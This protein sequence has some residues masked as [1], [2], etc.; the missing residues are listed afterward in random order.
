MS[1][2]P[3]SEP[4]AIVGIGC[5]LP[6]GAD[7]PA[8]LWRMLLERFDAISE[9]PPDRFDIDRLYD[10]RP[11]TPGRVM[12]RYGGFLD[13]IDGLDADFFHIAPREAERLDPQQRL[14]LETTWEAMED[15]GIPATDIAGSNTGVFVGLW[16]NDFEARLFSDLDALDFHMTTGTGRYAASGRLSYFLDLLGPSL[17]I[18]TA[19]SSSLVAVHLARRSLSTGECDLAFAAGANVILQP[20]ITIAYSQS[21]MMAP[22]GRCKFGDASGDGYVRSEGAAVVALKRLSDAV[23]HG[24]RIHAVIRGSAVTNDGRTSGYLATPGQAGQEIMLR[25]AYADAGV[26]PASVQYIEAH[27]TGTAAGDP[28]ELGAIGAVVGAAR[29]ADRPCMVG[30]IKTNCGHT[31]GAAGVA[32]LVK[33][34][35]ALE[36]GRV[37]PSL[38]CTEPNPNVRWDDLHIRVCSEP[39]ALEQGD[40]PAIAGVSSFGIAGTNAHVVLEGPPT[41]GRHGRRGSEGTSVLAISARSRAALQALAREYSELLT[42]GDVTLDDVCAAA[43]TQRTHLEHRMTVI[44]GTVADAVEALDACAHDRSHPALTEGVVDGAAPRVAFV[45]S[46]QGS[47]WLGMAR[48]LAAG[49]PV[50]AH[51]LERCDRA[52]AA[53]AGWSVL[54]V[55]GDPSGTRLDDIDVVQPVLFAV[56]VALAEQWAAWGVAPSVVVGHSM[57]EVA[58]AHVAGALSLED[59]VRVICLRSRQLRRISGRGAM[60]VVDLSRDEAL[61]A[62]AGREDALSIAA[63]NSPRS[64][65]IAG[66]PAAMDDVL[67]KL[68]AVDVFCRLVKVDVASHSPQVEPLL[69]D[70]HDGLAGLSPADSTIPFHSTV[71]AGRLPGTSLGAEYWCDNLRRPVLFSDAIAQI[72]A[73]G[74]V[75]FV[76]ISPHPILLP[77]IEQTPPGAGG[78][79]TTVGTLRRDEPEVAS[80]LGGL[81]TLHTL[82]VPVAWRQ[83]ALPTR[84]VDLPRYPWQRERYWYEARRRT[85]APGADPLLGQRFGD[86]TEPGAIHWQTD[87]D[88]PGFDFVVG[89]RVHDRP[90][91]PA[92][93]FAEMIR[94]AAVEAAGVTSV[95]VRDLSLL[96]TLPVGP[97]SLGTIQTTLRPRM[98]GGFECRVFSGRSDEWRLHA[99]ATVGRAPDAGSSE[100]LAID[101]VRSRCPDHRDA[102]DHQAR[103]RAHGLAYSGRFESVAECWVGTGEVLGRLRVPGAGGRDPSDGRIPIVDASLQLAIAAVSEV[104]DGQ[105]LLPVTVAS[106]VIEGDPIDGDVW[107]HVRL[108]ANDGRTIRCDVGLFDPS[109]TS[110]GALRNVELVR[111]GSTSAHLDDLVY[112]LEWRAADDASVDLHVDPDAVGGWIV[113]ANDEVAAEL[114]RWLRAAGDGCVVVAPGDRLDLADEDV[115]IEAGS[116][117]DHRA[118]L[119]HALDRFDGQCRGIVYAWGTALAHLDSDTVADADVLGVAAPVALVRATSAVFDARGDASPPLWILTS[120]AQRVG[121]D[122]DTVA[123]PQALLW[124]LG[125]VVRSE[126]PGLRCRLLDA[127]PGASDPADIVAELR[128]IGSRGEVA[129][130]AGRR[131][132]PTL[133]RARLDARSR[134]R[135]ADADS[136]RLVAA[137]PGS[138]DDLR[139][140][141][142]PRRAPGPDEVE[143]EIASAALN[144]LDVLKAMGV[145]P[146]LEPGPDVAL[147]AEGAGTVVAVGAD[148]TSHR[149]GDEVV[150]LTD[151]YATT[152]TLASH[153]T[154]PA[155]FAIAKPEHLSHGAASALPVAYVTAYYGLVELARL[156]AGERVLVHSATGGVGLAAIEIARH[157]GAEVYATAGT[158]AKREQLRAMGITHVYDSRSTAFARGVLA[159]TDGAGVDVVLNSLTG[160]AIPAGLGALANRGRFVELGK[161]DVYGG[162]R[163][164]MDHLKRNVSF[165]VVDLAGLTDDR[166]ELVAE[167]FGSVMALIEDGRLAPLPITVVAVTEAAD[168]FR[169][170]AQAGHVGKLVI[171]LPAE[172]VTVDVGVVRPDATYLITGGTGALGLAV[173]QRFVRLGARHLA[174]VGRSAPSTPAAEVIEDLRRSGASV[175]VLRADVADASGLTGVLAG[176]RASFP[177]I[178]GVVHAA[179]VLADATL[180]QLDVERQ[181]AALAPKL[182][183]GWNVHA[184]TAHDPLDFFVAFSSVAG[185]LGLA[186][187]ANYAA[188]NAFLDALCEARR[189]DDRPALSVDWGPWAEIGLAA[190]SDQRGGR[191]QER[192]L[193]GLRTSEALDVLERLIGSDRSHGVVM[194]FDPDRWARGSSEGSSMLVSLIGDADESGGAPV[195]LRERLHAAPAGVRRR[196]VMEEA[197][198]E[199]LAPVVRSTP[200]RI[201]RTRPLEAMGVD[202]LMALEFRNRLETESG[203][204]LSATLVF[205]YPTVAAI[206]EYVAV[207]MGVALD[208]TAADADTAPVAIDESN[209]IEDSMATRADVEALLAQELEAVERVLGADGRSSR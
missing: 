3:A 144:F 21:R 43:A 70:L 191:L 149:V 126:R 107:A 177:P 56:Q 208:R 96:E 98:E 113:Y 163:L 166:P 175:D 89:H 167:L 64:T 47:Q 109:G 5:R 19:C 31:E 189:L 176:L 39:H 36:H 186:G 165:F 194:R 110:V 106:A 202:S 45:F 137:Q 69:A 155:R 152:S 112:E 33:V 71:V 60:A 13:H 85:A 183:G 184:A 81:A 121:P 46:G 18:D 84:H 32:G 200:E 48:E 118:A 105:P 125:R 157:I 188:G 25:R 123:A 119:T 66:D 179:G 22:D 187:Q 58:A 28:V 122:D 115:T 29:P 37:P 104:A 173:A 65:V 148:V 20:T 207:R 91:L 101:D 12:S 62:I 93:G 23:D 182:A 156:R 190:A 168:A 97:D 75:V 4:I 146:G 10:P 135:D 138:L 160:E 158:E 9:V 7:T 141:I 209:Q 206:A 40:A 82:G 76:E 17:T 196:A 139:L 127:D 16:I 74:H 170:M 199:Q 130:R 8:T 195:G 2:A 192:G 162:A 180:D 24:D 14:L 72:V 51:A 145:Y 181:R 143:V 38:H 103:M 27:G 102:S 68:R 67:G 120:G 161:R 87:A 117:D 142:A 34:A 61:A 124:G 86:A 26:D 44:A 116:V 185:V 80:M 6:G 59:A 174:L 90:I 49:E 133:Q 201:D 100:R 94:A 164:P 136:F 35:L 55:L 52:I 147:G 57:G 205:N 154:V 169:T 79:A 128:S 54:D 198:C 77:A 42:A 108:L 92:A 153:V 50:F 172:P 53:A 140:R 63:S 131:L 197:V 88:A 1:A 151:S 114:A 73:D 30:S 111:V 203:I 11:A 41:A 150:V 83:L 15:A 178:R 99:S 132:E 159:D 95:E 193:G 134:T 204:K 171:S 78:P 129:L